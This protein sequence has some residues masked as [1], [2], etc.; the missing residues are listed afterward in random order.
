MSLKLGKVPLL[1]KTSCVVP[2]PKIPQPKD[3]KSYTLVVL[4]SHLMKTLEWLVLVHPHPLVGTFMDPLQFAYQPGIGVDDPIIFLLEKS[5]EKPRST[6]RIIF[7][8]F[9]S[10]FI[11]IQPAILGEKLE[12]TGVDQHATS[13]ILDYLINQPQYLRTRNSVSDTVVCSMGPL[14]EQ[15]WPLYCSPC[16]DYPT[17]HPTA[18]YK[19]YRWPHKEQGSQS[20]QR[21]YKGQRSPAKCWEVQRAGHK[22]DWT[23]HTVATY[24]K[25][26]SRVH[27]LRKL[28]SFGMQ[29]ALLITFYDSVVASAIFYGVVCWR[30][31]T[32]AAG[33]RRLDK[34]IKKASSI[35]GY[36]LD[37]VQVKRESRI[38]DKL[39]S[40]LVKGS[41]P[42]QVITGLGS[43]WRRDIAGPSFLLLSEFT[44]SSST[45]FSFL[46]CTIWSIFE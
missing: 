44:T 43:S 13:W 38:M 10:A 32:S 41:H 20:L 7:F 30:S 9:S 23:D 36:P 17:K 26:Q 5:L 8:D 33:T 29:G 19:S 40:L 15:S 16:T 2:V 35:L 21:T 25:G 46:V 3:I 34:L 39:S 22:L 27:L 28:R 11:T 42:L 1:W 45:H 12:L 24:K 4:T 6:V 31:S 37:P 18:I 14:R